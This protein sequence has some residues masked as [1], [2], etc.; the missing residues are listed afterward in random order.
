[1]RRDCGS[2]L[3]SRK[4]NKFVTSKLLSCCVEGLTKH[5]V[6]G[7]TISRSCG[8]RA[9]LRFRLVAKTLAKIEPV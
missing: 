9:R 8:C 1:M 4:F 7:R 5:G 2:G 3:L 6:D